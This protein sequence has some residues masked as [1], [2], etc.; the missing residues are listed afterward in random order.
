MTVKLKKIVLNAQQNLLNQPLWKTANFSPPNPCPF[1]N[2]INSPDVHSGVYDLY[3]YDDDNDIEYKNAYIFFTCSNCHESFM[4]IYTLSTPEINYQNPIFS[5]TK[6]FPNQLHFKEVPEITAFSPSFV[7]IY[8]ETLYAEQEGLAELTG[9]GFRKALEFLVRDYLVSLEPKTE[10]SIRK[11]TFSDCI[12]K[13]DVDLQEIAEGANWL[14]NDFVHYTKK[15]DEFN[16][17]DLK[18]FIGLF[19]LKIQAKVSEKISMDKITVIREKR[20][21]K[22]TQK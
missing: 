5:L 13:L 6:V 10:E 19:V 4:G 17:E 16:I 7:R 9:M 20:K 3:P 14:S 12:K 1:C 2:V 22:A 18:E 11:L 15:H 8:S 21:V